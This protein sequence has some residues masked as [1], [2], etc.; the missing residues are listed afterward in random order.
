MRSFAESTSLP[1]VLTLPFRLFANGFQIDHP[2]LANFQR[3]FE[4]MQD[5][6]AACLQMQVTHP[7]EDDLS[8]GGLVLDF[9]GGVLFNESVQ[10]TPELPAITTDPRIDGH[11]YD[12]TVLS[13]RFAQGAPL[14]VAGSV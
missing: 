9:E 3:D 7:T 13:V 14:L 11:R 6:V 5:A 4:F 10:C 8:I 12:G 1:D 2:E